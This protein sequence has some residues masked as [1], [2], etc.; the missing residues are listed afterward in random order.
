MTRQSSGAIGLVAL[1]AVLV[2]RRH[3]AP[4]DE[5]ALVKQEVANGHTLDESA[6][7]ATLSIEDRSRYALAPDETYAAVLLDG[8]PRGLVAGVESHGEPPRSPWAVWATGE[9]LSAAE[10][11]AWRER[12]VALLETGDFIFAGGSWGLSRLPTGARRFSST[13]MVEDAAFAALMEARLAGQVPTRLADGRAFRGVGASFL[14]SRYEP[15]Q[16]FAPHFDG[17]GSGGYAGDA[18]AEYTVVLY[19]SEGFSGGETHYLAGQGSEVAA[20]VAVRPPRGCAVVH[21]QGTVLHAGGA[22]TEGT[23]HIMQFFLYYEEKPEPEPRH[24]TNLRWGA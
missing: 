1:V 5:A 21:R 7:P 12:D 11:A 16:Y 9:L 17:R 10:C 19:L 24:M 13:R 8:A 18:Q 15:G 20:N 22:V 3:G 2:A 23:K 4:P 6:T 14:V